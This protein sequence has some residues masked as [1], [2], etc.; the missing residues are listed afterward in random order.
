[1]QDALDAISTGRTTLIIAHKL[2]TVKKADNIAVVSDGVVVEQGSHQQLIT[3]KGRYANLVAAQDLG[4]A[5]PLDGGPQIEMPDIAR[6]QTTVSVRDMLEQP[7]GDLEAG[8][9]TLGYSLLRC[10]WI[11]LSEQNTLY[12][13]FFFAALGS[14]I[15]GATFPG[16]AILYSRVLTVFTLPPDEGQRQVNFYALMFFV[17]ALGNLLAYSIVGVTCNTIGQTLTHSYRAEMLQNILRQDIEF[18]DRPENTSGALT[19]RITSI[20]SALNDL[21]SANVLLIFIVLVNVTASSVVAIV[22][23]W[24]LGLVVVFGG[25]PPLIAAGYAR[26]RI[27]VQ[28]ERNT[29]ERFSDSASL[30]SESVIAIKTVA[31]LTLESVVIGEYSNLLRG[32]VSKSI[33]SL[34]WNLWLYSLSQ[35]IE[36]LIMAL[37]FGY[38]SKLVSRGEYTVSQ[39]YVIF[40]GVLFAAQAAGQFFSYTSSKPP[41]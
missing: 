3:L 16:Q 31:S 28:L 2:A 7:E 18:F 39:F 11:L 30:A 17:I 13:T 26:M 6:R 21:I 22:F 38:G 24:K 15:G 32:I 41:S 40:I 5:D 37:G 12:V 34:V 14:L 9:G 29:A 4:N 1:M 25:F 35:A 36:F 23:G 33:R 19:A 20:P 10:L 8:Q 27:E